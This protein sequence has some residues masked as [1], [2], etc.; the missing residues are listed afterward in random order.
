MSGTTGEKIRALRKAQK[1]TQEELGGRVGVSHSFIGHVERGTREISVAVLRRI[2]VV[3]GVSADYL[4]GLD[5]GCPAV[6]RR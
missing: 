4:L 3:L 6:D 5:V 1:L 2:C